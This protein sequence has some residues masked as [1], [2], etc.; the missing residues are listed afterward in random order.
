MKKLILIII[1]FIF[2]LSFGQTEFAAPFELSKNRKLSVDA[3]TVFETNKY[4]DFKEKD[5]L[6]EIINDSVYKKTDLNNY[7]GYKKNW[8]EIENETFETY[9]LGDEKYNYSFHDNTMTQTYTKFGSYG[10]RREIKTVY[11]LKGFIINRE[12]KVFV[13]A[14]YNETRIIINQFDDKNRVLKITQK[15]EYENK[16]QNTESVIDVVYNKNSIKISSADGTIVC[17]FIK[18]KNSIGFISKLS[19]RATADAFMYAIGRNRPDQAKEFCTEK[20][21]KKVQ[22]I[23]DLKK[24]IVS[25]SFKE[26]TDKYSQYNVKINDIWEIKFSTNETEKYK[27]NLTIIKQPNGWKIDECKIEK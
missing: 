20:M 7:F 6:V 14:N 26:G 2:K 9:K 1:L 22:E 27:V 11:N 24:Q 21:A 15:T 5:S 18:D 10:V 8:I 4:L 16:K 25:V 17:R 19:P 12:E 3:F 13:G 23:S